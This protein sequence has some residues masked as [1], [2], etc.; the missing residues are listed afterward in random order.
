MP[1]N[2]SDP[3]AR[4]PFQRKRDTPADQ[5]HEQE[6][7]R[8]A[9]ILMSKM[10]SLELESPADLEDHKRTVREHLAHRLGDPDVAD[11]VVR[12]A[13]RLG[14]IE[15]DRARNYGGDH[16]FTDG[17]AV[18]PEVGPEVGPGHDYVK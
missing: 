3:K 4:F 10:P 11:A 13:V 1:N 17:A 8:L 18:G 15:P 9:D 6:R 14:Y 2:S 5:V 7:N 16:A 12:Y